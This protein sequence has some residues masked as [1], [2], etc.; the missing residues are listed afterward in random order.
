MATAQ[1]MDYYSVL[2]V[3][4]TATEKELK[5]AFR[6]L[7][8]A[9][10]PDANRNNPGAEEQ[11]KRINQAYEVLSD[12]KSRKLYDRYGDEWERYR[13]AGFTGDE[14]QGASGGMSGG[15]PGG[16]AYRTSSSS[17]TSPFE[18]IHFETTEDD[19]GLGNL[20]GSMFGRRGST[21]FDS[22]RPRPRKG[23]DLE[24]SIDITLRDAITGT[25]RRFEVESPELCTTCEGTGLARGTTCPTCDGRGVTTRRR[26]LEVDIPAGVASGHRIRLAGQAGTGRN[27]GARGDVFLNVTVKDDPRFER[28]GENL[29]T[30]VDVD[31]VDAALG[32]EVVVTTP[33]TKVALTIPPGTQGGRIFR[34]RNQ[35]MPRLKHPNERGDLLAKVNLTLPQELG[36][37]ERHLFEQLR[38]LRAR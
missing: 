6:K 10:H 11:F 34:L 28:D 14:P 33:T 23:D 31:V 21:T 17:R 38:E 4:R 19:A 26:T 36:D 20:F 27:G 35:G 24:V 3:S 18:T 25:Q 9:H 12:A 7:A 37:E 2:G 8:R 13:D 1:V 22:G 30:M 15:M 5:A 16:Y 32:G 29:R